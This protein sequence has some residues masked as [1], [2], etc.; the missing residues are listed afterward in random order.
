MI[1]ASHPAWQTI[2]AQRREAVQAHPTLVGLDFIEVAAIET[3]PAALPGGAPA[4]AVRL[5]LYFVPPAEGVDKSAVPAGLGP[6]HLRVGTSN[7]DGR[8]FDVLSVEPTPD[9]DH[10]RLVDVA[11]GAIAADLSAHA[12]D[13]RYTL[14]LVGASD[15][16]PFFAGAS[17]VLAPE[18]PRPLDCAA[19]RLPALP[20]LPTPEIDYLARDYQAF[21][22]LLLDRIRLSAPALEID[23]PA[24][25]M[26]AV[27][28]ALAAAADHLSYFQDAVATEAYLGTA[29]RRVS[30]RRHA[31][32]L[33]YAVHEGVNA[34]VWVQIDVSAPSLWMSR[35]TQLLTHVAG[36]D[37]AIAPGSDAHVRALVEGPEVFE[38]MHAAELTAARNELRFHTWGA[39]ELV[40]P[41]GTTT[42]TLIM[43]ASPSGPL[44]SAGDVLIFE[45]RLG[46]DTGL[47]HDADPLRRH[48]VRLSAVNPA[49][50]PLA[51]DGGGGAGLAVLDVTWHGRDAL[52]FD[53][54]VSA[55]I[56]GQTITDIT[57]ARGN[58]VLAD[59]GRTITG[60]APEL[61]TVPGPDARGQPPDRP[62]RPA[63][64]RSGIV[65][66]VPYD[67]AAARLASAADAMAQDPRRATPHIELRGRAPTFDS[68]GEV[69]AQDPGLEEVWRPRRDLLASD[70]FDRGFV[71]E[72]ETGG[73]ARLRFGDG[74]RGRTPV[75]GTRFSASYRVG[76]AQRG[77]VGGEALAHVVTDDP[78]VRAGV[79][80]LR[81]ALPAS[82]GIDPEPIE[83]VVLYAPHSFRAVERCVT[84]S[85]HVAIALRHPEVARAAAVR[86]W[87]GSWPVLVLAV[88]RTRL[89]VDAAFLA[90]VYAFL[91]P[92]RLLGADL[93]VRGPTYIPLA[94]ALR[95][96]IRAGYFR[97]GVRQG[98]VE[99]LGDVDLPD[100]RR[101]F[102]HP[103]NIG[104]GE[105]VFLSRIITTAR[106]VPGVEWV[107]A[108]RFARL[109]E[110]LGAALEQGR[111]DIGPL[112]IARVAND[113]HAPAQ[114]GIEL[115]LEGGL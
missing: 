51:S 77:N 5:R 111:I 65:H 20:L 17:F 103:A 27:V 73:E 112:E 22:K 58:V 76:G 113:P 11:L 110:P 57:V 44:L 29:R 25:G 75:P 4:L 53:M 50:D 32:L 109:G 2:R 60:E 26:H 97:A 36:F 54:C 35:G 38:T 98:L 81:N 88:E 24:D 85:D 69:S 79:L 18:A 67:H 108:T 55:V 114:G 1:D 99:A 100:G 13:T 62:F 87:A 23:H 61:D 94:I 104:F 56:G 59:H 89:A 16:D 45:E 41:A 95:V 70:R 33:D 9:G 66:S 84:E 96:R 78:L 43:T 91:D 7:G 6:S 90:D 102:F 42:A 68:A 107:A 34:R 30:V 12:F 52:P 83:H 31:R 8:V 47:A 3:Q 80:R 39:R 92:F 21:R 86:D 10:I 37:A 28:E 64:V 14:A 101:G 19:A 105:P 74:A 15:V 71:V 48:V 82:G 115:A 93:D 46:R 63:L 40:L 49:V 106:D 72:V